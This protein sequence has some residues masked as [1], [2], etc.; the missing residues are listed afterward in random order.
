M[1]MKVSNT[2]KKLIAGFGVLAF[3]AGIQLA[4]ASGGVTPTPYHNPAETG[5]NL[6]FSLVIGAAAYG[7]GIVF[8]SASKV[9]TAK[10]ATRLVH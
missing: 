4:L 8:T 7:A 5:I 2:A 10:L 1:S 9:I 6:D 3:T